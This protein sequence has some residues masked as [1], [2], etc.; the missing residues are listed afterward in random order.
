VESSSKRSA[1]VTGANKGIG[2]EIARQLGKAGFLV[3]LGARNEAAGEAAAAK[4]RAEGLAV[5][6]VELDLNRKETIDAAASAIK[7]SL[8]RPALCQ[9][10]IYFLI[11]LSLIL[12]FHLD[13]ISVSIA[14]PRS[15][16]FKTMARSPKVFDAPF[17]AQPAPA[18]RGPPSDRSGR[19]AGCLGR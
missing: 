15:A 9:R 4:L 12:L 19:N 1:L 5:H 3:F 6:P 17:R 18:R 8:T 10:Y 11:A 14:V 2:L 13:L 7:A 16:S